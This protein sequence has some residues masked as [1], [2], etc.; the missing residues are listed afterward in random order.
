MIRDCVALQKQGKTRQVLRAIGKGHSPNAICVH[1][2]QSSDS[3]RESHLHM[4]NLNANMNKVVDINRASCTIQILGGT[5]L[6]E[7]SRALR[8]DG[9][10]SLSNLPSISDLTFA[11]VIATGSHGT[12]LSN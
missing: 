8:E 10:L 11:G 5:T 12:G 7:I 6:E 1:T 4:I 3:D 2:T 9:A